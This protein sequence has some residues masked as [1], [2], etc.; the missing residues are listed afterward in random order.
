MSSIIG[1]DFMEIVP[2]PAV[3]SSAQF[4]N[5]IKFTIEQPTDAYISGKNS[6]ISL[7][8]QIIMTRED[9]TQTTLE[10]IVNS[11][12]RLLPTAIS[13]PY[14][15]QNPG[16]ALFQNISCTVNNTDITNYQQAQQTNTLYRMLYESQEEEKTT[17]SLNAIIPMSLDDVSV[18]TGVVYDKA[19]E[20]G[21]KIG[22]A[23]GNLAAFALLFTK[24]MTW[25]LKNQY[26][27]DKY[28]TNKLTF[29]V[30]IPLFFTNDLIYV[31]SNGK[32]G[33]TLNVDPNWYR[34]L[35][36]IAGSNTCTIA[37][38][39]PYTVTNLNSGFAACSIN[40]GITDMRLYLSR[41]HSLSIPRS[42]KLP[43]HLKQYSTYWAPLSNG[44]NNTFS[45]N[46]K[47]GRRISHIILAFVNASGTA[48][49][50]SPTDFSSGFTI[51]GNAEQRVT[52]DGMTNLNKIQL[53]FGNTI[54]PLTPYNLDSTTTSNTNDLGRAY[55]DYIVNNDGLK[56]RSGPLLSFSQWQVQNV[57]IFKTRQPIENLSSQCYINCSV[58]QNAAATNIFVLALYDEYIGI[59]LDEFGRAQ[60]MDVSSSPV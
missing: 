41:A 53:T 12:T 27:F 46:F 26:N 43:Y 5:D 37:N 54:Y 1:Y 49:K 6:Y 57:Y 19:Y 58:N 56:D 8:V 4:N 55:M 48:F 15:C 32:I 29:Q 50:Y 38:G 22:V 13:V 47:D 3:T 9:N 39:A 10:P 11:G 33:I 59:T 23:A 42:V 28:N 25:A 24:R 44:T 30:P 60:T 35:I 2:S 7:G 40:V 16:G 17:N 36:Q 51:N 14:I 21:R 34:N 52:N 45:F 18:Q 31:G 20:L